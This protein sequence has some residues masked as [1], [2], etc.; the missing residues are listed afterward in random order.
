[1]KVSVAPG[2]KFAFGYLI[3]KKPHSAEAVRLT[4]DITADVVTR[5]GLLSATVSERDRAP[6]ARSGGGVP[7]GRGG[8]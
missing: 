1:M 8:G 7:E 6:P 4:L 3:V 5:H 2:L